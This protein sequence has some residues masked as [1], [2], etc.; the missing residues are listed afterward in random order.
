MVGIE[1][2]RATK[3]D[4]PEIIALS[5]AIWIPA[6]APFFVPDELQ[7]LYAGMYNEEKIRLWMAIPEN[8]FFIIKLNQLS[9][10]YLGIS[11]EPD[12]L[13][14]DKI[15]IDQNQQGKGRG[16]LVLNK[17]ESMAISKGLNKIALRVNRRNQPAIDFYR[18]KGFNI[19]GEAD[20]PAPNGYVY[21]DYLMSK[22]LP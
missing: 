12:R 4:I 20:Y 14:L 2:H 8:R 19:D 18:K 21:D 5:K 22:K 9:I 7:T 13:W 10:G 6:F 3:S 16:A 11:F 17:V 1:L 15:Y